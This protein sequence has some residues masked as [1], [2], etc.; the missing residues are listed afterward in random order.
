MKYITLEEPDITN[1]IEFLINKLKSKESCM[2]LCVGFDPKYPESALVLLNNGL[3]RVKKSGKEE[4]YEKIYPD[5]YWTYGKIIREIIRKSK[6][7]NSPLWEKYLKN[8]K[9]SKFFE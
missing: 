8:S 3:Y 7:Q 4:I 2:G 5:E 9:Y 6:K 1:I